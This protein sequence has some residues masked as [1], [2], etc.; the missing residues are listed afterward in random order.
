[1]AMGL[2]VLGLPPRD[3]WAMTPKELAAAI[4]G[5]TGSGPAPAMTRGDLDALLARFPDEG[6][7]E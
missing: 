5:R 2:G 3:F 4:R 1:M 6:M 7:S